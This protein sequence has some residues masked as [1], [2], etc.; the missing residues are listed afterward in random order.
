ML[1]EFV[2]EFDRVLTLVV[3]RVFGL[4]QL[5]LEASLVRLQHLDDL[6]QPLDLLLLLKL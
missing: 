1:Y 5:L 3:H 6:F 4:D 2:G